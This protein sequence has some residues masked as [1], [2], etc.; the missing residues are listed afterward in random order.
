[1][2]DTESQTS[3]IGNILFNYQIK[4]IFD[5]AVF[6]LLLYITLN[7]KNNGDINDN[8]KHRRLR[9]TKST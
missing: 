5:R 6:L 4:L 2:K 8:R 3:S 9:R 1:M 7:Q